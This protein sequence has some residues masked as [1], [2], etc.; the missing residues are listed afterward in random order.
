[1][2]WTPS[3]DP[4]VR[5]FHHQHWLACSAL[6][7]A[8]VLM[9]SSSYAQPSPDLTREFQAGVD[10]FRLGK[11]A[12]AKSHLE[13][14]RAIDPKLPGP[15]RFLAA[16]AQAT[17]DWST[18]IESAREA[19]RL[20]PA[21]SEAGDTRKLHDDCRQSAGRA[22]FRGD[23]GDGGAISV[24][25]NVSGATITIRGLGYGATPLPPRPL[26]AGDVDVV[27]EKTGWL[28]AR[29]QIVVIPGLVT[30]VIVELEPDPK[31]A[32]VATDIGIRP[33]PQES[34]DGWLSVSDKVRTLPGFNVVAT[35]NESAAP[36]VFDEHGQLAVPPG[37]YTIQLRAD[38]YDPLFRRVR[39]SKG[40]KTIIAG[41]LQLTKQRKSREYLGTAMLGTGTALA[42][43]GFTTMILAK[44][45]DRQA[46]D[47]IRIEQSRPSTIPLSQTTQLEPLHTRAE[48]DATR[49]RSDRWALMSNLAY[50]AAAIATGV[51][52]GYL[53]VA[54]R[55]HRVSAP[56][57]FALLPVVDSDGGRGAMASMQ[58]A[59][60]W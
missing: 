46:R 36:L 52:I 20:N 35:S 44:Q 54:R 38:G 30:D 50:G 51:G 57:K 31:A 45:A 14:A 29:R 47:W 10:S 8:I 21:S 22:P 55:E 27:V 48:I 23:F 32:T 7:I 60:P 5:K 6:G 56:P 18:C 9:T 12:D 17:A 28:V 39:V 53:M 41:S 16:V 1:M 25:S 42:L 13:K 11:Y 4:A 2:R 43:A 15:H 33:T 58:G 19:L 24:T 40:Q 59:L 37:D 34:K 49:Q 26:A 3:Y